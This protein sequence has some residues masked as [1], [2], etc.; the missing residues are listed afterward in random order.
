MLVQKWTTADLPEEEQFSTLRELMLSGPLPMTL[1]RPGVVSTAPILSEMELYAYGQAAML[2]SRS[3]PAMGTRGKSEISR[4]SNDFVCILQPL[5]N[6]WYD[7]PGN[8]AEVSPGDL[9]FNDSET[10]V[11]AGGS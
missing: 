6:A 7:M 11:T 2:A 8:R 10:P 1:E 4:T 5:V 9:I 3:Q